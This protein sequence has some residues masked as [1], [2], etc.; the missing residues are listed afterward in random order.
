VKAK[1]SRRSI[2][3]LYAGLAAA[4]LSPTADAQ[5]PRAEE[6]GA[7]DG[8]GRVY[9]DYSGSGD[10]SS[11]ELNPALLSA[12]QGLDLS[13]LGY[14]AVSNFVRGSGFGAFGSLNLGFGLALGFG[15]QFV[16][17]RLGQDVADFAEDENP[18]ITKLS[19]ALSTGVGEFGAFGLA[20]HGIRAG[21]VWLQRPS[22]DLGMLTRV[23]N[24]GSV[25]VVAQFSPADIQSPILPSQLRLIGE[26]AVRPLGTHWLELAGG[27]AYNVLEADPGEPYSRV[28]SRGLLPRGRIALRYQGIAIKGEVEQVQTTV[29]DPMTLTPL[30]AQKAVRGSVALEAIWDFVSVEGGVSAGVSDGLDAWG[31]KARL[32][33]Q[34]RGRVFWPRR[35]DAERLDM[36]ELAGERSLIALLDRLERARQAGSRSVLVVDARGT[37]AGWASLHEVREALVRVRD[38]GGHVFAYLEGANLK[39]YYLA[40]VAEKIYIHPAG[41]LATYGIASRSLYFAEALAKIGVKAEVVK[42]G[43]YKSAGERF[44]ESGPTDADRLQ[45]TTLLH[46]TFGQIVHD[47]ARG[48]SMTIAAVRDAIDASPHAPD[49]AVA[50]GLVDKVVY[51]DELTKQISD[52]IGAEVEFREIPDTRP[53]DVTWSKAPYV[54]VVLV[55]DAIVD[56]DS[57]RIP[58]FDLGFTGGDTIAQ[59][60]RKVRRDPFCRGIVLRVNSP[61]GS[62]LASDIIWREVQRT[63]EAHEKDARSPAIVVSMSDVAASGGYYVSMGAK[64]VLADPMT[65]TGSIGVISLHLDV[66]GLLQRLGISTVTF[67]E[68]ELADIDSP[69]KPFSDEERA[70]TER[71]IQQTYDLFRTRVAD[72]RG[73]TK[74]RV[75]ELGQGRVYSGLA[76]H[77]AGLVDELGGLYEALALLREEMGVAKFRELELRVLPRK[78]R[79]LDLI[80]DAVEDPFPGAVARTRAKRRA[81]QNGTTLRT[82]LPLALDEALSR[83]PLSVLFLPQ[84]KTH[85]LMPYT[86]E[87]E[88]P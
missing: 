23:F 29:L 2:V 46:D 9:R 74:A 86:L 53:G 39:D 24:Y 72:G 58:F 48:R 3:A 49:E 4:I 79:L 12:T 81:K 41:G 26:A 31:F 56:G 65:V 1:S 5:Q 42:I 85:A 67:K 38:A 37:G 50:A 34:Q 51:R 77:D 78:R 28:G 59:T 66:S 52:D 88:A 40:S 32:H 82:M 68:G 14:G 61:G 6:R 75:H 45:R 62:A 18:D 80:L 70:R 36:S 87:L 25:G 27:V 69:Y 60:L 15:A 35:V 54:A 63:S 84:R 83:L 7:T 44:T 8:V 30:R 47:I 20:V 73:I 13:L 22:L 19:W 43:D 10:A 33:T 57:R 76:A 64:T 21:G 55:E 16:R 17:P 71:S 11:I